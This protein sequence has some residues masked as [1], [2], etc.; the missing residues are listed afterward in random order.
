MKELSER[1]RNGGDKALCLFVDLGRLLGEALNPI[2]E[3]FEPD[4]IVIG[5][6]LSRAFDLFSPALAETLM[7]ANGSKLFPARKICESALYGAV[8]LMKES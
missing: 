8:E 2:A 1:A 5:G 3:T 4:K 7:K 6:Q